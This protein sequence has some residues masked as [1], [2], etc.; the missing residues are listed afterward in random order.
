MTLETL[1]NVCQTMANEEKKESD[2]NDVVLQENVCKT[3]AKKRPKRILHFSDGDLEEYSS[4]DEVDKTQETKVVAEID[5][6][7]LNWLPWTWYKTTWVGTKVLDGCDYLGE[8]LANFFGITTP[9]YQFEIDEFHRLQ[10]LENE[11]IHKNDLEMGGWNNQNR[12][13][14]VNITNPPKN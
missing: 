10:A 9:K 5:P 3:N 1:C 6:H 8:W 2:L 7:T 13:N 12:N 14:L 4:E 11:I